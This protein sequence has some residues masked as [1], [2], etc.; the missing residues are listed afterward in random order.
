[1]CVA[2]PVAIAAGSLAIE[3]GSKLA[4]YISGASHKRAV[5]A[6]ADR[7]ALDQ[8][9]QVSLR[10]TQ[11]Q[12]GAAMSI[13]QADRQAR[14]ADAEARVS[15]GEA[16]V[17]GASVDALL[18]DIGRQDA[19]YKTAT[20]INLNNTLDQLEAEKRGIRVQAE[21]IK[22]GVAAPSPLA[23]GVGLAG[24][25]LNFASFLIQRQPKPSQP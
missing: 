7:G 18:G 16:G 25:G 9:S 24:A 22:A 19:E 6:A 5:N 21:N 2:A 15:A 23:L 4:D 20:D 17:A 11:T 3:A 1:M 8:I 12:E 13:M 10:E 14:M